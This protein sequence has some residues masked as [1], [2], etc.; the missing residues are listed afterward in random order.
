MKKNIGKILALTLSCLI[1]IFAFAACGK[2]EYA[3]EFVV[4]GEVRDII[5]TSGNET[6]EIMADP[7]KDGYTFDGWYLDE[8]T[9]E[10]PF[11]AD[12]L[13][14][15]TFTKS[16]KVY[17]KF[18]PEHN[19]HTFGAWETVTAATCGEKG[20]EHRVCTVCGLEETRQTSKLAH[21]YA[22]TWSSSETEHW[23]A[24]TCGHTDLFADKEE[25]TFGEWETVT[26]PTC[27]SKGLEHSYCTVC[28]YEGTRE[29]EML[30]HT[31]SDTWMYSETEHLRFATCEHSY[32]IADKA[33]HI[34]ETWE[35]VTAPTCGSKGVEHSFC[36]VCGYEK[37]REMDMIDHTYA[38]TWTYDETEHWHAATC[39]HTDLF[40]DKAEHTFGE[41]ET[42]TAPTCASK[43]LEHRLC[44]A[45]GYEET[46]DMDMIDHTYAETW[47]SSKTEHWHAATCEH[48]DLFVDKG[49]HTFGDWT[50]VTAPT[51]SKKG[52]E[53]RLCTVCGYEETREVEMIDHAF[54]EE[55]TCND[56]EH[57]H[58]AT[59]GHI[60]LITSKTE[61]IFGLWTDVE[62]K[63]ATCSTK[64]LQERSC[65]VCGYK[66]TRETEKTDHTY[67]E[68]WTYNET[69][70]WH[71]ASCEHV[72]E[73]SGE[74][75]HTFSKWTDVE[76]KEATCSNEGEQKRSCIVCGYEETRKTEKTDHTYSEEWTYNENEH[77]HA[78][79]CG[80]GGV[81]DK[82]GHTF[83][84]W[85]TETPA[86]CEDKGTQVRACVVC[87]YQETRD[88]DALD[89]NFSSEFKIDLPA[90][91]TTAGSKSRHCLRDGCDEVTDVTVIDELGHEYGDW[92][93]VNE[94][95][96]TEKGSEK[97][98]CAVCGYEETQDID[99]LDH[100]YSDIWTIDTEAT[101]KTAGSKSHHC[102]R[103]GCDEVTDVTV[104]PV[105][106]HTYDQEVATEVYL[107][108][109]A[110]CSA[111]AQ[112]YY[113]C[114]CGAKGTETFASGEVKEGAHT[115]D[116][117]WS[118]NE[119][120]HWR[121][122]TCGDYVFA[123]VGNHM[124]GKW[125]D[126]E[127]KEATCST[128][129][130]QE[131]SCI[132]CGY[133]ETR[134]TEKTDHTYS[135][136]WTCNETYH[137]HADTCGHGVLAGKAEHTFSA[138]EP[139][140]PAT[141]T[142][143][144]LKKHVCACGYEETEEIPALDHS[145]TTYVSDGN[146]TCTADGTK[147]ATC[148]NCTATDTVVNTGS[149]L[150]HSFTNYESNNDATCLN[151]GTKTAKCDNDNCTEPDTVV[152]TGSKLGHDF[153]DWTIDVDATYEAHGKKSRVCQRE[154]CG[155]KEEAE[156]PIKVAKPNADT[157]EFTYTGLEQTYTLAAND[158]LYTI[159]G[160]LTK[161]GAG[162]S[163]ITVALKDKTNYA[164][165]DGSSDDLTFDFV[166]AKA[167]LTVAAS[168]KTI[169]AG[170]TPS[171][172]YTAT[173]FVNG[174]TKTV[175]T[176][177]AV[178]GFGDYD[179]TQNVAGTYV[180]TVSGLE[181]ANYDITFANGTLTVKKAIASVTN[182]ETTTYKDSITSMASD[183]T[184]KLLD[185]VTVNSQITF[186]VLVKNV[187]L[188]LNGHTITSTKSGDVGAICVGRN[189]TLTIRNGTLKVTNS[190]AYAAIYVK[191]GNVTLEDTFIIDSVVD[192]I[193]IVTD[194]KP[195][196]TTA[197]TITTTAAYGIVGNGSEAYWG[198]MINVTGGS[199]T[200]AGTGIYHPQDGTLN[201]SGGTITAPTPVEVRAGTVNITGGSLVSNATEYSATA[202][203][204][205]TTVKGAALAI[206]QHTTACEINVTISGGSFT[207]IYALTVIDTVNPT[208]FNEKMKI[209]ISG[210]TFTGKN[211]YDSKAV[212]VENGTVTIKGGTF[213]V[214]ADNGGKGN[215]TIYALKVGQI[216]I[217]GGEFS[218]DAKYNGRYW[219]LN[220]KN[221]D[222]ANASIKVKG[223]TFHGFNPAGP[224]TD[225]LTSYLFDE[226]YQSV[227]DTD[228]GV[229]TVSEIG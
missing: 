105:L 226:N 11:S 56:T 21:T 131:R 149:K 86:T 26:E 50:T 164:W 37:T 83:G 153:G 205:G 101:C 34:F 18:V 6:I 27:G 128:K 208:T 43:G 112:Y 14:D 143:K 74:S 228:N 115:Y 23:H 24:A 96:C 162:T 10:S 124:F 158:L 108:S 67:S 203:G 210:G 66:E 38:E 64:G 17:A 100:N 42:V 4:D 130:L 214:G 182:G 63:E 123:D 207:G 224:N 41:W 185:D 107:A 121:A 151:D 145:F 87:G 152:D 125:T 102:L 12:S 211:G 97:H 176:G 81:A 209:T 57:W 140:T 117:E 171:G 225:D 88:I 127:G 8:G 3:I 46:R 65:R 9:W 213:T 169:V 120:Q 36:T 15:E 157:T 144:G 52:V 175:L 53:H 223:G 190:D 160:D 40:A 93:T 49:V 193:S 136:D 114:V 177:D 133:E 215:S 222:E 165:D 198:T 5:R 13:A 183:G 199:I 95:N 212:S 147:T 163:V 218:S 92:E 55:W 146:A 78:A 76:G 179:K 69:H 178:Y 139:V 200:S 181:A 201:I 29:I 174:E 202:N 25:H 137:W 44:T 197:A 219:V 99:A 135:E 129:G 170:N 196:L 172:A 118:S 22:K 90:T 122:A 35:T 19:V 119:E 204:N 79:I 73:I 221:G 20:L 70:H 116:E 148:D 28:G 159:T 32:L 75:A 33:E 217:E 58:A 227:E 229:W 60:E 110:T 192:A 31:Y 82:D 89:H 187:I 142:T 30:P 173:G 72:T 98:V 71:D 188:D 191:Q 150:G 45:C 59:C 189:M 54:S 194:T 126:V 62:G 167:P 195:T 132:V 166:I 84:L 85:T 156:T 47:S 68:D 184:W 1:A 2:V 186:T 113:S 180:I 216:V 16:I 7:V 103:E 77:Y 111:K 109:E 155:V 61:H 80:H 134:E 141:C 91:C 106:D 161:T 154:G 206:S 104:I 138:W 168:K 94:P 39:E 48:T 220:I 51:C